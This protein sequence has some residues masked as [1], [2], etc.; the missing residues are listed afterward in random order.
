MASFFRKLSRSKSADLNGALA[1]N[2]HGVTRESD[3]SAKRRSS[4]TRE[5]SGSDSKSDRKKQEAEFQT[6]MNERGLGRSPIRYPTFTC[7]YLGRMP[8]AGEFGRDN[9]EGPVDS[10][11]KLRERQKLPKVTMRF[12]KD[13][14]HVKEIGG[15]FN[16]VKRE[17]IHQFVPLHHVS[18]GVGSL[19]HPYVFACITRIMDDP[20]DPSNQVL[21]L[22]AFLCD[23]PETTRSITYWQLQSYIEAYEELKRK[24]LL[25]RLRKRAKRKAQLQELDNMSTHTT[26]TTLSSDSQDSRRIE[27]VANEGGEGE[28]TDKKELP[29][30]TNTSEKQEESIPGRNEQGSLDVSDNITKQSDTKAEEEATKVEPD[31]AENPK[32]EDGKD[33]SEDDDIEDGAE[34]AAGET[35]SVFKFDGGKNPRDVA[36]ERRILELQTMFDMDTDD[37]KR[38][39]LRDNPTLKR[40]FH[41]SI[42]AEGTFRVKELNLGGDK[43]SSH[44]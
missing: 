20:D 19:I 30:V 15:P 1:S 40:I 7:H 8:A 38:L 42:D 6:K 28:Q 24:K 29:D 4:S 10:L 23:K 33:E 18:Y 5:R 2:H 21:V 36:F 12:D 3:H 39:L 27:D 17:G 9:V 13:G 44:A 14:L 16:K 34:G 26:T 31:D 41:G 25:R 43:D 35:D 37:L 32:Q 22:H 11:C